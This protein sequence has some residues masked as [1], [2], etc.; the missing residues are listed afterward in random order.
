MG[1]VTWTGIAP[2]LTITTPGGGSAYL[3]AESNRQWS[4]MGRIGYLPVP[5]TLLYAAGG[6]TQLNV[7][8]Y[9]QPDA[10]GRR[11]GLR[12]AGHDVQ[13]LHRR[14]GH[15]DGGHRGLDDAAGISL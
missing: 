4:V 3:A 15:R 2:T 9:G 7:H 10:G 12:V 8:A 13:R 6:Y 1:D 14:A 5:S 11:L